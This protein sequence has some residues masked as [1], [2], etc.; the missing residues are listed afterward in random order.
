M[1]INEKAQKAVDMIKSQIEE[2]SNIVKRASREKDF[3]AARERLR[4]W[5]SR[6]AGLLSEQIHPDEGEKLR[7]KQKRSFLIGRHLRNLADEENMYRG[8]LLSLME[9]VEKHPKDILSTP[10]ATDISGLP[11]ETPEPTDSR[12]VFIV[13]GH[14]ELN[15]LRLEK[16]LK[17]RWHLEPIVLSFEPDKGG[18]TLIEK[19]EQEAQR[20]TYAIILFTPD[21]LVEISGTKYTQARPNVVFELGWFYGHL[22]RKRVCILFKKGTKIHSDLDGIMRIE[23]NDSV[24]EKIL[25]VEKELKEAKLI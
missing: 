19:F 13:H 24:E 18:R 16:L 7:K 4:R 9:E 2:L 25:D 10:L 3:N 22:D 11:V 1:D 21:D 17:D 15:T 8:F 6:T 12:A 20:V 14:D 23:F 5:K